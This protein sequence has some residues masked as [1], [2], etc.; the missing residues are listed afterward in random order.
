ME[1]ELFRE[2][3]E[4]L[5]LSC[6]YEARPSGFDV[7]T[8]S[9]FLQA[10]VQKAIDDPEFQTWFKGSR[11]VDNKGYPLLVFHGTTKDFQNFSHAKT[12]TS[13]TGI[14]TNW[15]G[16]FFTSSAEVAGIYPAKQFNP[17]KG[18]KAG[19]QIKMFFLKIK[20]PF[21][22]T[23][24]GYWKLSRMSP[25]EIQVYTTQLKTKGFDGLIMPSVWRGKSKGYDFVVFDNSQIR[26]VGSST[27]GP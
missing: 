14:S 10:L 11:V 22:I 7:Q 18:Y 6:L 13:G 21:F 15:L 26:P 4:H 20:N 19:A 2:F 1:A 9:S 24:K 17:K 12:N 23:E 8:H 25:K 27:N 3:I 5:V 16:F